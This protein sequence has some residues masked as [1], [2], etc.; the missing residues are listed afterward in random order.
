M[1]KVHSLF[2]CQQCGYVS[3]QYLG[4]CPECGEW[5]SLV[6]TSEDVRLK[7]KDSRQIQSK[8]RPVKLSEITSQPKERISTGISELDYIL[9]GG[10]VPGQVVLLAGEP[11]VGKS[12]LLLQMVKSRISKLEVGTLSPEMRSKKL[13]SGISKNQEI[14]LQHQRSNLQFQTS[15]FQRQIL[16]V[17]G[18]ESPSQ[19]ALRAKRLGMEKLEGLLLF[20]E[21]NVEGIISE[22]S[23]LEVRVSNVDNEVRSEKLDTKPSNLQTFKPQHPHSNF[24][25]PTSMVIIDSIQTLWSESLSGVAG[26]VGQVRESASQIIQAAKS[27][28]IPAIIVGQVTKEG[29]I[30]GPKVLEHMVDTV[31]SMEG[32]RFEETRLLRVAKNRFGPTDEVGVFSMK[33]DGLFAVSDPSSSFIMKRTVP[34]AG[35][36]TTVIMEGTRPLLVEIQALVVPTS[37]PAPRRVGN[38]VIFSRLVTIVAILAKHLRLPLER[39]DVYVNVSGGFS[40]SEPAA[41]AAIALAIYSSIKNKPLPAHAV[42]VGELSLLGELQSVPRLARRIKEAKRLGFTNVLSADS[43]DNLSAAAASL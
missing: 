36:A 17:S 19:I 3:P 28:N 4:R 14:K 42:A 16:Y 8:T 32:A 5:N 7:T 35:Q 9:G 27:L 6:E 26:S 40:V 31:L 34:V 29:T 38:G 33:E 18:E 22:M 15:N 41:D 25:L 37:F 13:D 21:T 20:N 30:A 1:A 10:L 24:Q 2:T 39:F 12:T 43:Y 11:G 23:K